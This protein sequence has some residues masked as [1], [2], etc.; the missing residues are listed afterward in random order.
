MYHIMASGILS[1]VRNGQ[2]CI[3]GIGRSVSL[4]LSAVGRGGVTA[5]GKA[6]DVSRFTSTVL[7]GAVSYTHL[8]LPTRRTV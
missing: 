1:L 4:T 3:Q 2:S 6:A 5:T 8:T 7:H